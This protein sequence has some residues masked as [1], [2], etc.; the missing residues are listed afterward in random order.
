[1]SVRHCESGSALIMSMITLLV[2]TLLGVSSVNNAILE[3]QMAQ[4]RMNNDQALQNAENGLRA[5]E[6]K[7]MEYVSFDALKVDLTQK[8]IYFQSATSTY[9]N[10]ASWASVPVFFNGDAVTGSSANVVDSL[11]NGINMVIVEYLGEE[12]QRA[13]LSVGLGGNRGFENNASIYQLRVT[14][15]GTGSTYKVANANN[16]DKPR[17]MVMLQSVVFV[18][19]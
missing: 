3:R 19:Y 5:M 6:D 16:G 10:L 11:G 12:M 7:L 4:S 14:S 17:T 18:N 2:L 8:N 15:L 9:L 13:E 1:M